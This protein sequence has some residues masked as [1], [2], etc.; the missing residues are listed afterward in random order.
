MPS[1]LFDSGAKR[2]LVTLANAMQ[3]NTR[4]ARDHRKLDAFK[5]ADQ[6]AVLLYRETL[7]FPVSERYGLQ[8]QLR[9]TA[10]SIAT[11]IVEGS[12]RET[13]GDYLRFLDIAFA[14]TRELIYLADL[15]RRLGFI[16]NGAAAQV[17]ELANQ[18]AATLAALRKALRR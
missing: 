12:A 2:I 15:S 4:M 13:E 6:L 5:L 16:E 14:S 8:A 18:T 10:V 7:D 17:G 9:R 11:N 1:L 3:P